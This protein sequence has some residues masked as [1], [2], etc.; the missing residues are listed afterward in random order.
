MKKIILLV[1]FS[2]VLLILFLGGRSLTI[3]IGQ[4]AKKIFGPEEARAAAEKFINKNLLPANIKATVK[5]AVLEGSVYSI[6][7]NV[8]GKDYTSYMTRD[9]SKFFQSG[10]NIATYAKEN[11]ANQTAG[12]QAPTPT[13]QNQN[14]NL[15]KTDK[16]KVELFV[17]TYCPYG[18]QAE[19]GIIPAVKLLGSKIDFK[20]RQ[21]GAMHGEYEKIEAQRQLCIEKQYSTKL[22]DYVQS[23]ALDSAIG[24][25]GSNAQC[26][27]PLVDAL[28]AKYGINKAKIDGCMK[29]EGEALYAAE[30]ANSQANGVSGSPT[31]V[32]NGAQSPAG[33]D[34]ASY[35]AGICAAFNNAPAEC[36]QQ[37]SSASPS[38]GF[39]Q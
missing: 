19:K 14:A 31:L 25:C 11:A 18:T 34:S 16:P 21:I 17:F 8:Q 3:P 36:A 6:S 38:A 9:G 10:V 35:L 28:Y 4:S 27:E 32:I 13:Q 20:I 23:F 30:Q 26:S 29:T 39:G 37:L 2:A 22:L 15:P 1:S 12:N 33:R 7:L 24:T 5:S